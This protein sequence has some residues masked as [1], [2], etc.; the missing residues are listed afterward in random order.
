MAGFEYEAVMNM[1]WVDAKEFSKSVSR[2]RE[3]NWLE[4]ASASRAASMDQKHWSR[5]VEELKHV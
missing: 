1:T 5:M 2:L 3:Q 4:T